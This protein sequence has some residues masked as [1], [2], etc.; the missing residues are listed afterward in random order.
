M[1]KHVLTAMAA[2]CI[3]LTVT[4]QPTT[5]LVAYWPMNGNFTDAGPNNINVTNNGPVTGIANNSGVANAAMFFNNAINSGG[6]YPAAT[7]Y[8]T[9]VSPAA[10]SFNSTASFTIGMAFKINAI[11]DAGAGGIALLDN[12]LNYSGYGIWAWRSTGTGNPIK[13]IFNFKNGAIETNPSTVTINLNT[14]YHIAA[15]YN[16]STAFLYINGALVSTTG[17]IANSTPVYIYPARFGTLFY[18]GGFPPLPANY[19]PV[20]GVIDEVRIYNRAL[21]VAEIATL[22]SVA[23]PVK[24]NN[25]TATKNNNTVNLKWQTEYEQNSSH[26]NIQRSTDG[27]NFTT[28]GTVQAKGTISTATD[29]SFTDNT[30][31][32]LIG[33]KAIY[34]R[35]QQADKDGRS[36]LS[37]IVTVRNET[38]DGLLTVLQNPAINEL[39]LQIAVKQQQ[40]VQVNITNAQGQHV[41]TKQLMLPQGQTFTA[42]PV[43]KLAAGAYYVTIVAGAQK[44]TLSFIK[45]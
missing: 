45:Q 9:F 30:S 7:Q 10:L 23:L 12:N 39:R 38:I 14:W 43:N 37:S 36:E 3:A 25:F 8:A 35:L 19:H 41:S 24:L 44:Q 28:I 31:A 13:M 6:T 34:Y 5:G 4:A 22:A 42:L 21:S 16:G 17:T 2:L 26:F 18:N 29:Y 33:A 27:V 11:P 1:Q 32:T 15:M 40:S 20:N